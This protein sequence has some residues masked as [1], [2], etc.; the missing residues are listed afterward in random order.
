MEH[1]VRTG[2]IRN[3]YKV[4]VARREEKRHLKDL[5]VYQRITFKCL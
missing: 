2:E 4:L 5:G 1:I 3:A